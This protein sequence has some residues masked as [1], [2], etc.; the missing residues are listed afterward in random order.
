MKTTKN[1][2]RKAALA[3]ALILAGSTISFAQCDKP[4]KL[5]S[6]ITNYLN[7]KER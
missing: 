7:D 1:T 6:S 5:T 4:V 2:L 3:F